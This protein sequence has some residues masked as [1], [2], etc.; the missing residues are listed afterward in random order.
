[1]FRKERLTAICDR[2]DSASVSAVDAHDRHCSNLRELESRL[3]LT[4]QE[5]EKVSTSLLS[6]SNVNLGGEPEKT[7]GKVG[8]EDVQHHH[9]RFANRNRL[10]ITNM[11][12]VRTGSRLIDDI[13]VLFT[14]TS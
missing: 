5:G 12:M 4:A 2:F 6:G 13:L 10:I 9:G 8:Q 3:S 7:S 14:S 1:M 11:R